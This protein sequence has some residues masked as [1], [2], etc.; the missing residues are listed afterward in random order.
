MRYLFHFMLL[1]PSILLLGCSIENAKPVNQLEIVIAS[2][3]LKPADSSIFKGFANKHKC[4]IQIINLNAD[5]ITE[6][7]G[8]D[9]I[10]SGI[11]II[12]LNSII[13]VKELNK[14]K[15]LHRISFEDHWPKNAVEQ[16]SEK[17]NFITWG[18]N[19]IIIS[20]PDSVSSKLRTYSDM[21]RYDYINQLTTNEQIVLYSATIE[22]LSKVDAQNWIKNSFMHGIQ[23]NDSIQKKLSHLTTLSKHFSDSNGDWKYTMPNQYSSGTIYIPYTFAIVKQAEN[24]AIAMDFIEYY[25]HK[26]KNEHLNNVFGTLSIYTPG[27]L[28]YLYPTNSEDLM[29]NYIIVN[30]ILEKVNKSDSF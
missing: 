8:K 19:P 13:D 3:Y 16:G 7:I 1:F 15:L 4:R 30:R 17:Y 26:S 27:K 25:L 20:Y 5:S 6:R 18:A 12:M 14:R 24:Y 23:G 2:D 10:N 22:E 11:D 9:P 29:E 28:I 21:T